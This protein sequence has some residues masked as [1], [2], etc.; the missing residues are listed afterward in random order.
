MVA[1]TG[2]STVVLDVTV[3]SAP[4]YLGFIEQGVG[5]KSLWK[6]VKITPSGIAFIVSEAT[7][8]GLQSFDLNQLSSPGEDYNPVAFKPDDVYTGFSVAH[9]LVLGGNPDLIYAT[10]GPCSGGFL[11]LNVSGVLGVDKSTSVRSTGLCHSADGYIHDGQCITYTGPD[12]R[13]TGHEICFFSTGEGIGYAGAD[14]G[15]ALMIYDTSTA[16]KL[17]RTGYTGR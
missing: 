12:N 3:G 1:G 8:F 6:D 16:T 15:A 11:V 13:F 9:N 7:G 17:S 5:K 14:P 10:G 4:V 2:H